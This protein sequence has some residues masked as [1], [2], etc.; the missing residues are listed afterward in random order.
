MNIKSKLRTATALAVACSALLGCSRQTPQTAT[1]SLPDLSKRAQQ[2]LAQAYFRLGVS[3]ACNV[4]LKHQIAGEQIP[5]PN[6]LLK[7]CIQQD[8]EASKGTTLL[9]AP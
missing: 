3:T 1:E 5:P 2:E 6:E 4:I 9:K 8:I 7:E